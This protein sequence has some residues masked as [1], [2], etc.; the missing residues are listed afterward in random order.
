MY[1][2]SSKW[3]PAAG[4]REAKHGAPSETAHSVP[5]LLTRRVSPATFFQ[6]SGFHRLFLI[7]GSALGAARFHVYGCLCSTSRLFLRW[8]G[9]HSKIG[10]AEST[11]RLGFSL[12]M[13]PVFLT[14]QS[15]SICT[16]KS[17]LEE[18]LIMSALCL[19][20]NSHPNT[21]T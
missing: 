11:E 12:R 5:S 1:L 13:Q 4:R 18:V 6:T 8:D 7:S 14:F 16:Q 15:K 10:W 2:K 21:N 17:Q 19:D 3:N 9:G 20:K